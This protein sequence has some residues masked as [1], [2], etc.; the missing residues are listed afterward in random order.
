MSQCSTDWGKISYFSCPYSMKNKGKATCILCRKSKFFDN[1]LFRV[2]HQA[3]QHACIMHTLAS[4]SCLY[5]NNQPIFYICNV[6][7]EINSV[8]KLELVSPVTLKT[9]G[10]VWEIWEPWDRAYLADNLYN[11]L[12]ECFKDFLSS[13]VRYDSEGVD[14][15]KNERP[16]SH[17]VGP[18]TLI[19]THYLFDSIWNFQFWRKTCPFLDSGI[20]S[21]LKL[22]CGVIINRAI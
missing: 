8:L 20:H 11:G 17:S 16:D 7:Y 22:C 14:L 6:I 3:P 15:A 1:E 9:R 4:S 18:I 12:W 2:D 5:S 10:F 21:C 19:L 13:R